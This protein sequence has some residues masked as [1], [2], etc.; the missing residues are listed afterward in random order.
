MKKLMMIVLIP[1][2]VSCGTRQNRLN[3]SLEG[4]WQVQNSN[5]EEFYRIFG[6][7]TFN[8]MSYCYNQFRKINV[9]TSFIRRGILKDNGETVNVDYTEEDEKITYLKFHSGRSFVT[10]TNLENHKALVLKRVN[11]IPEVTTVI[12]NERK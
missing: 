11:H 8:H 3:V 2:L 4:E 9:K 12:T 6:D 10:L 7:N 5:C 1:L